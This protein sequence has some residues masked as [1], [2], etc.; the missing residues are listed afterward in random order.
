MIA[1]FNK[2]LSHYFK[3]LVAYVTIFFFLILC[4]LLFIVKLGVYA[5]VSAEAM[6]NPMYRSQINIYDIIIQPQLSNI[7]FLL[8]FFTPLFTMRVFSEEKKM[9]TLELLFT[10]P[11]TDVQ[12]VA[13]KFLGSAVVI[14]S[15]VALTLAY[16]LIV[17]RLVPSM[18][19]SGI[20]TGY[21]GIVLMV[22]FYI[23]V[24]LWIS[25]L[26]DS[27]VI[28]SFATFGALLV[29]WIIGWP[30]E[31]LASFMQGPFAGMVGGLSKVLKEVSILDHFE[32]F[33][34]GVI[35]T[36]DLVFFICAIFLFLFLTYGNLLS[37]RW[38][39]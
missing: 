21:I 16:P 7:V 37:R 13:G 28:S 18:D 4:G 35:D 27:Q 9:G 22:L 23:A 34:K 19:W 11:L 29:F 20:I 26:T 33:S 10:Y 5:Q 6:M 2:E 8:L 31:F 30:A 12:L 25:S 24:G 3:S 1:I 39:G 38:K 14:L 15:G 36:K 17:W 32:A